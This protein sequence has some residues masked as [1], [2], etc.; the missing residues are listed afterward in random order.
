MDFFNL[1]SL[2]VSITTWLNKTSEEI[3]ILFEKKFRT[4]FR[5]DCFEIFFFNK[6]EGFF[7]D[8]F[9]VFGNFRSLKWSMTGGNFRRAKVF[10]PMLSLM[11]W[12]DLR[13]RLTFTTTNSTTVNITVLSI[14]NLTNHQVHNQ[15]EFSKKCNF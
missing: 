1:S 12:N 4:N 7:L 15:D 14:Q 6:F 11:G 10:C 13:N 2:S 3:D 9:D 8:I 5:I